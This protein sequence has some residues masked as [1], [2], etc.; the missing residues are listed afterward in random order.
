M[1]LRGLVVCWSLFWSPVGAAQAPEAATETE[2][3]PAQPS[4]AAVTQA[5]DG[6]IA[7]KKIAGAVVMISHQGEVMHHQAQGLQE[8]AAD[9]PMATDTIFRIYSMTKPVTSVAVLMLWERGLVEL[10]APVETYLPELDS[11][12]VYKSGLRRVPLQRSVTVRDLMRHTSGMTYGFFSRTPVDRLYRRAHPLDASDQDGLVAA[13]AALPLLYQPGEKWHYS[14]STDVLGALVERVSGQPLGEFFA[15]NIFAPP[16]MVDTGFHV[17]DASLSR[18]AAS[19]GP[20][21][22]LLDAPQSSDFRNPARLQTGGGGLVSTAQDYMNFCR[23]LLDDGVFSGQRLL[24][25]ATVQE[26]ISNQLPPGER[27][28][29]TSGFGLGVMI[30]L[31]DLGLQGHVGEYGWSGA[32]STHFWISPQDDLILVALSQRQPYTDHLR[33]VLTPLVYQSLEP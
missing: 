5:V 18:F 6:L 1:R 32:A 17:P 26:M 21:L 9:T 27:L 7:D 11:L 25:S 16:Q 30:K 28:Y 10:D 23:M 22:L 3:R 19:Y 29:E 15:E 33:D 14:I 4:L 12:Q 2:N 8:R 31:D 20:G 13:L 24:Q